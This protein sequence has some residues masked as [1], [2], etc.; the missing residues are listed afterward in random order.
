MLMRHPEPMFLLL[1]LMDNTSLRFVSV[2]VKFRGELAEE[3]VFQYKWFLKNNQPKS[4]TV[5]MMT[6]NA[7]KR[8][9]EAQFVNTIDRIFPLVSILPG[10]T[11]RD[12]ILRV[13]TNELHLIVCNCT[14]HYFCQGQKFL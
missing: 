10:M 4:E 6:A 1:S 14:E 13:L 3:V 11:T 5:R 7:N 9:V 2:V 8:P 12:M